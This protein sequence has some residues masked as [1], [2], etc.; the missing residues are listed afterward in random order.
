[1]NRKSFILQNNSLFD[2]QERSVIILITLTSLELHVK[3]KKSK[4][5]FFPSNCS[6][7]N[8]MHVLR[9][10]EQ[11]MYTVFCGLVTVCVG[12]NILC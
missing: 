4:S 5:Y 11:S 10:Q 6:N 7:V 1:M 8:L 2:L 9:I 3:I 12:I